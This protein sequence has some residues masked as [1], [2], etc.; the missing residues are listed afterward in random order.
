MPTPRSDGKTQRDLRLVIPPTFTNEDILRSYIDYQR[1]TARRRW[2]PE[3]VRVRTSQLG[4]FAEAMGATP[5]LD[6]TEDQILAWYGS[7]RGAPETLAAYSS[8]VR[9]LYHWAAVKARPRLRVDDPAAILERPVIP[10]AP[11]RPMLDRHYELAL[12]CA[13]SDPE[14]YL[15]LGLMGCSG[16]RCCEVAWMQVGDVEQL[17]AGGALLHITGKG[18]KRRTVPAGAMLAMTMRP[19]L[20]G[21]G[22]VFT[23]ASDGK[24]Y[25]PNSVSDRTNTFLRGIGVTETAHQLRHRF[26]TDYHA[27]DVDVFRQAAVMGHASVDTTRRY[28][29]VSPVEA[30]LHIETLTQ[31]RYRPTW[32]GAA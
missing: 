10:P 30:A 3:T 6:V 5:L 32:A 29:Q 13:V 8:A 12:A 25:R 7:L 19:F 1:H 27:L 26:G 16:L 18:G 28:T 24:P 21:Q 15:W 23:R 9:G 31:R 20:R 14:M 4:I 17:D 2:R 22:S 11:P